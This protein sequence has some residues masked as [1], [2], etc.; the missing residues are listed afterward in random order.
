MALVLDAET[1]LNVALMIILCIGFTFTYMMEGFPNFAHTGYASIGALVS[2]YLTRIMGVNPYLTWPFSALAGG[3]IGV[4]LYV[5]I[6]RP[7]KR[8]RG[9]QDITLTF[10]FLVVAQVIPSLCYIF[11]YWSRFTLGHQTRNYSLGSLDF[12]WNGFKGITIA[13]PIMCLLLVIGVHLFLTRTRLGL[14]LR[15]TSEDENLAATIGVNTFRAHCASWFLSGALAALAGSIITIHS[16]V[17][18]GGADGLIIN[19]MSGAIL[20][21]LDSIYGAIIGGIFIAV[22]QDALGQLIYM[23]FG[24]ASE[25]WKGLLPLAFLLIATAFFP[26]GLTSHGD[27]NVR[28]LRRRALRALGV[29]GD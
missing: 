15:A 9:Y 19:V 26:N 20:G 21:G 13:G 27:I 2:F 3:A 16:G 12:T 7:I 29:Q 24:L 25:A 4:F 28:G 1:L 11:N 14:S 5:C 6:V 17:G 8:D 23:A 18:V 10:T 22:A